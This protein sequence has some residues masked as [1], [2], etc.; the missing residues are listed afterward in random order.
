MKDVNSIGWEEKDDL[1]NDITLAHEELSEE[2]C[3]GCCDTAFHVVTSEDEFQELLR[4]LL[5]D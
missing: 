5:E 4:G 2:N 3:V 1:E